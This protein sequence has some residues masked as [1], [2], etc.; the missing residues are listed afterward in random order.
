MTTALKHI[1]LLTDGI[2][3]LVLGGMQKH[4]YYLLRSLLTAGIQV[5]LYHPGGKGDLKSV[6]HDVDTSGLTEVIIPLPSSN[7]V[8]GSYLKAS[9]RYAMEI[10]DHLMEVEDIDF[11]YAQG[12]TAWSLLDKKRKGKELPPVG[13]NFHGLEMFQT[14]VGLKQKLIQHMFRGPVKFN[15]QHADIAYSLGGRLTDIL[16]KL[17]P[18]ER[19]S[20]I[21]IALERDWVRGTDKDFSTDKRKVLFIGRY[22]RRKGIEELNELMSAYRGELE[23]HLIGPID[24]SKQIKRSNIIYHGKV[25]DKDALRALIDDCHALIL[26]S[27]SEG[28]PTVILE[29]M[30]R[31]LYVLATDVGAVSE[32]V[33]KR[34]GLLFPAGDLSK[35]REALSQFE[36]LGQEELEHA[37]RCAREHIKDNYMWDKVV[38]RTLE[39]IRTRITH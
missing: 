6:L 15:L 5:S 28:M 23:F 33:S 17:L 20:E 18:Q 12:F 4:S 27:Y 11:V 29:A 13:V 19:V 8:P 31:G 10:A 14:A 39:D 2:H 3:P 36:D 1:A 9:F 35:M 24:H 21:S 30:A 34:T 37:S 22:E 16:H 26:C 32:L 7:W 38:E 25:M